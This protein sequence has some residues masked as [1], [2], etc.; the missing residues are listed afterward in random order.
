[1]P[2]VDEFG[3]S[4]LDAMLSGLWTA[5]K[6]LW[7]V[8]VPAL[9]IWLASEFFPVIRDRI[10]RNRK[11]AGIANLH[12]DREMLYKLRH[13]N[14][15]EFEDY[16]ANLYSRLG[17]KTERVGQSHDGGIDVI[18]EKDGIKHYIQCKK[19]ITRKVAVGAVRD[20]YGA[21]LSALANGNGIF[22]TTNLF[23]TEAKKFAEDNMIEAIDGYKLVD[24]VKLSGDEN[25]Q[26]KPVIKSGNTEKCSRCGGE[27]IL[28]HGKRG[29]FYGCSNFPKCRFI[30]EIN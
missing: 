8:W 13:L 1:M 20:F 16:I 9:I 23:T 11:F 18:A 10:L 7:W 4:I 5:F 26:N 28:R 25:I 27:L 14:P 17:Y 6:M 3:K 2:P 15:T 29:S 22:I 30:R 21:T 19:F 24:L 12:S